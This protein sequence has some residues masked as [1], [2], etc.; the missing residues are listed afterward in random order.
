MVFIDNNL[1]LPGVCL[2]TNFFVIQKPQLFVPFLGTNYFVVY[3]E[4]TFAVIFTE[5]FLENFLNKV[6]FVIILS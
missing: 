5:F 6:F 2:K 3:F 4:F 1:F